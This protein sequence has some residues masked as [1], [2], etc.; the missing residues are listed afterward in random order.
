MQPNNSLPA[1]LRGKNYA[2][3]AQ[4]DH[5][6]I[7]PGELIRM[8][9]LT[10]IKALQ[11]PGNVITFLTPTSTMREAGRE[12]VGDE[13]VLALVSD[14]KKVQYMTREKLDRLLEQH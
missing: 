13:P 8:A 14:T 3:I 11:T 5:A 10:E 4:G 12:A 7:Y 9:T 1:S 6:H 2:I